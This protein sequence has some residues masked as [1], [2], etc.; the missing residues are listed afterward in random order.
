MREMAA[1]IGDLFP[2]GDAGIPL[3]E[4]VARRFPQVPVDDI[5]SGFEL[6]MAVVQVMER[7]PAPLEE[8][9]LTPA[10]WRL[11]VALM[12]QSGDGGATIGELAA[13]LDVREPTVT[14][15]VDRLEHDGMVTRSRDPNDR[16]VV[17]VGLTGVGAVA[18]A[19]ILPVLAGR[20]RA[21]VNGIGGPD[22]ARRL[23]RLLY[24]AIDRADESQP[25]RHR[26][27]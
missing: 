18:V 14:A 20:M 5:A 10:R 25:L 6:G 8:A 13:H 17:R 15:T 11:L 7:L 21:F 24:T 22:E 9:G 12:F 16:R 1:R 3:V 26:E 27:E 23:A 4:A 19:E 2:F